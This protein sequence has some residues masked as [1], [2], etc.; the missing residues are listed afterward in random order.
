[1]VILLELWRVFVEVG[2]IF[3]ILHSFYLK[4]ISHYIRWQWNQLT[5]TKLQLNI[6]K[7]VSSYPLFWTINGVALLFVWRSVCFKSFTFKITIFFPGSRYSVLFYLSESGSCMSIA[8]YIKLVTI[9]WLC[10]EWV[11]QFV[12]L[13]ALGT[14]IKLLW[15]LFGR[16]LTWRMTS[17]S[18]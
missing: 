1:M 9:L 10:R 6:S 11:M 5:K 15:I 18:K 12:P 16:W 7:T 2:H 8:S 4:S 17:P 13:F 3:V 14:T